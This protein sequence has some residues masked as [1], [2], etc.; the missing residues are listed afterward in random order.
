MTP[1]D[2]APVTELPATFLALVLIG[3]AYFALLSSTPK[4]RTWFSAL[5]AVAFLF[6]GMLTIAAFLLGTT[7]GY[8]VEAAG[9]LASDLVEVSVISSICLSQA[10]RLPGK[11]RGV[12]LKTLNPYPR[13]A[14]ILAAA[15]YVLFGAWLAA[16][17][18]DLAW[19]SPIF[20]VYDPAP[21]RMLASFSVSGIPQAFYIALAGWMF[22]KTAGPGV[23]TVQLRRKNLSF[24][25]ASFA[26]VLLKA[27][28]IAAVA[29]RVFAPDGLRQTLI[30]LLMALGM[31]L[32]LAIL[33]GFGVGLYFRV[34]PRLD[35]DLVRNVPRMLRLRDRLETHGW[36]DAG[37]RRI[38]KLARA[39]HY[40]TVAADSLGMSDEDLQRSLTALHLAPILPNGSPDGVAHGPADVGENGPR[41][42]SAEE[43][44]ELRGLQRRVLKDQTLAARL[45]WPKDLDPEEGGSLASAPFDDA[46]R[47][48]LRITGHERGGDA[49]FSPS[50]W[51][52]LAAIA[53]TDCGSSNGPAGAATRAQ[54]PAHATALRAYEAA[55]EAAKVTAVGQR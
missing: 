52:Q 1:S 21:P 20:H 22:A 39:S 35:K 16:G 32:T 55:R 27:D 24:S 41:P 13:V 48:A 26:W 44:A 51:Y 19:P 4:K 28:A 49:D 29:V 7:G 5:A 50:V 17:V 18:V 12:P 42:L 40:L 53:A 14:K 43:L 10:G 15:P 45:R 6:M 2:A 25:F 30:D 31:V 47:A 23:P 9:I 34:A 54:E 33:L 38:K 8:R 46:L 37:S 11:R 3:G 36:H